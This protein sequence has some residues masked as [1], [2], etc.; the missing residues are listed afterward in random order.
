L[1]LCTGD[2]VNDKLKL[3]GF[4]HDRLP[5]RTMDLVIDLKMSALNRNEYLSFLQ[6]QGSDNGQQKVSML[7]KE[8]GGRKKS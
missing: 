6:M 1:L 3:F 4:D 8:F 5:N 7:L 2:D